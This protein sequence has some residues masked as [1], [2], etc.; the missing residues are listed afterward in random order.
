MSANETQH[1][2]A[3]AQYLRMSTD[4]QDVSL[5]YQE[6]TIAKWASVHGYQ[7]VATFV[8]EGIS[9]VGIEKR[10]ALKDLLR[11]V[12]GGQSLFDTVLVYDVSR[13]GRFQNTDQSA[14]YEFMCEE[15]GVHVEY[16]AESFRNDGSPMSGLIKHVKRTMAAEFSRESSERLSRTKM[17]LR[18]RGYW[19]GSLPGYG[20]RRAIVS[21]DGAVQRVCDNLERSSIPNCHTRLVFGPQ[22]EVDIVR[23]IYRAFLLE[24]GNYSSIS[25]ELNREGVRGELG[26]RWSL[27]RIRQILRNEKYCGKLTQGKLR[28]RLGGRSEPV[29]KRFWVISPEACPGIVTSAVFEQVQRKIE[30]MS[31]RPTKAEII[32][33]LQR[34]AIE[35]GKLSDRVVRDHCKY[36]HVA[37]KTAFGGLQAAYAASGYVQNAVQQAYTIRIR[38]LAKPF[39]TSRYETTDLLDMLRGVLKEHG[40]LNT[41]LINETPGIPSS[42]T[43]TRRFGTISHAYIAIGYTPNAQQK[44]LADRAGKGARF[45]RRSGLGLEFRSPS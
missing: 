8:D 24:G 13:W 1:R 11:S 38:A 9:G 41:D 26:A 5:E 29:D 16:C 12:I 18:N 28:H 43:F 32:A 42:S 39:P 7:I 19:T 21:R 34:V 23:R 30:F 17:V 4:R 40:R 6:K 14:H 25:R 20:Y 36:G 37:I 2:H 27:A 3:A 15:A 10:H 44:L 31:Y 35:R 22:H 45:R 33:D